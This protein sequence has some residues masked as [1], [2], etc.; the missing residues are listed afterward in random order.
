MIDAAAIR[1]VASLFSAPLPVR[2]DALR[3]TATM[4]VSSR[5]SMYWRTNG[6]PARAVTFQSIVRTSSPGAYSRSSSNSEPR[7]LKTL[8]NSPVTAPSMGRFGR[9]RRRNAPRREA[10]GRLSVSIGSGN[11]LVFE[12][13]LD[14]VVSSDAVS[15]GFV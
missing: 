4:T 8:R 11:R 5:S 10:A 14:Q 3:S 2:S 13:P 7:P 6:L 9:I 1:A 12:D 15:L